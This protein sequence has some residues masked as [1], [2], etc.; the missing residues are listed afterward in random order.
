MTSYNRRNFLKVG[1]AAGVTTLA[2]LAGCTGNN[3]GGG[4]GGTESGG[5]G[6]T[7]GSSGGSTGGGSSSNPITIAT[8]VPLTGQFSSIGP[9]LLHGY[10][11]GIDRMNQDNVLDRGAKLVHQDDESDPNKVREKLTQILSDNDVD[12]IWSSFA[13][14]LIGNQ[15]QL[16][17]QHGIPLLAIAQSNPELHTKNNTD[18]LYSPFPMTH[19]HV[20][21]TK[22]LLATIPES[23]RPTN[24]GLWVPNEAWSVTMA[25]GWEE[26]LKGDYDIVLREKHQEAANDF[27]TIISK[28]ASANVEI[29]LGTPVPVGGITAMKQIRDSDFQPKFVQFVRAADTRAWYTALGQSGLYTCMSPGWVPG[30]TGNGNAEMVTNFHKKFPD[31]PSDQT[32][33]VM[34]GA[35]YNV[36]QTAQQALKAAGTADKAE[37]QKALRSET[38]DTVSSSGFSF[39]DRGIPQNFTT[40][41]GQWIDGNQHLVYP[42]TDGENYRDLVF[43]WK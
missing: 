42:K 13:D 10:Q 26:Q 32:V 29:L 19:D 27:S 2:G 35:T 41:V 25:D 9:D 21:S 7:E 28:S 39:D 33:P 5:G 3:G 20:V 43:P 31:Y 4:G 1:G 34:T 24:V 22:N 38:F 16:A 12:M 23:E 6:G 11:L 37:V 36:T 40:P 30:L 15:V 14:I 8:T 17:E 18:W